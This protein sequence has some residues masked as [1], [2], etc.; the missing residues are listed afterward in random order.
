M[1][2]TIRLAAIGM[3]GLAALGVRAAEAQTKDPDY[4]TKPITF[5]VAFSPGG[6][7]DLATRALIRAASKSLGQPFVPVNKVGAG[8]TVAGMAVMNAAPDG[9]TLGSYSG[10]AVLVIPHTPESPYK[11]LNGFTLLV[12]YGKFIF[13]LIVRSD[14][15]WKSWHD[16]IQW[17]KQNPRGVSVATTG[18]RSMSPMGIALWASEQK[19]KVE[20]THIS[21]KGSAEVLSY[22]LGGHVNLFAGSFDHAVLQS[23][24]DG[25]LRILGYLS[26]ERAP[27]FESYPTFKELY[28]EVPPNLAGVWGPSGMPEHVLKRLDDAF[29]RA[30]K[31]PDFIKVMDSMSMPVVYMHRNELGRFVRQQYPKVGEVMR[32]LSAEEAKAKK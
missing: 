25:R 19:E 23:L 24:K 31:D 11:N 20:F 16:L 13:P 1:R 28:G 17:A 21:L 7:V 3:I 32:T 26:E 4:P 9:Y 18:A 15:P 6:N 27:G 30:V 29:A 8:G 5:Y 10:S 14:S 12:N 22:T 2:R